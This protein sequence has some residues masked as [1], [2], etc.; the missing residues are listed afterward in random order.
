M[1]E[2]RPDQK[3]TRKD[4]GDGMAVVQG[5][6]IPPNLVERVGILQAVLRMHGLEGNADEL[7]DIFNELERAFM[8][9]FDD[10]YAYAQ[11]EEGD[12]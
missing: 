7:A 3:V 5:G 2:P 6:V 8:A 12:A 4:I 9:E 11:A 10:G 1:S